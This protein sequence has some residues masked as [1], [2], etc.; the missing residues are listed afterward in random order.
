LSWL[1]KQPFYVLE[2]DHGILSSLVCPPDEDGIIWLRLFATAPGFPVPQAW[3]MLWP[4]ALNWLQEHNDGLFVNSLVLT[5]EMKNLLNRSGFYEAYQVVVL[6]GDTA[7]TILPEIK[8]DLPVRKMLP[9][10][11]QQVY[12]IDQQAF[13]MIW[14]NSMDQLEAAYQE[15]FSAT[16]IESDGKVVAYQIS[17][18]NPKGGHLARLAVD[19]GYQN[20]G[21]A[22]RLLSRLLEDFQQRGIVEVTVNTQ[23]NNKASLDLYQKFGFIQQEETYPVLQ[24]QTRLGR[25]E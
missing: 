21:Y 20:R 11:F 10:D 12:K 3:K 4:P 7:R 16:V 17:T 9:D 8:L 19:P 13:E 25:G 24:Y 15:A 22:T 18:T 2:G 5:N 14:R 6:I 1:G 23:S